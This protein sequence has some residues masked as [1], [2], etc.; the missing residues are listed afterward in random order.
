MFVRVVKPVRQLEFKTLDVVAGVTGTSNMFLG[1]PFK[2]LRLLWCFVCRHTC[3]H[4]LS[5][6]KTRAS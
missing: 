4:T 5:S 2:L 6:Y 1:P 3:M